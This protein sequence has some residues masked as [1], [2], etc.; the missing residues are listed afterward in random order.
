MNPVVASTTGG[1]GPYTYNVSPNLPSGLVLGLD[2]GISGT[3]TASATNATYRVQA[4]DSTGAT[5]IADID[6]EVIENKELVLREFKEATGRFMSRRIERTLSSDARLY[7]LE[8]RVPS[9]RSGSFSANIGSDETATRADLQFSLKHGLGNG[10]FA[11]VEGSYSFY[12]YSD[13][14]VPADGEYAVIHAGAD[15]QVSSN[16]VMGFMVSWDSMSE[17]ITAAYDISGDGYL[18]GPYFATAISEQLFLSG[19]LAFGKSDNS[20]EVDIN[21]TS[22]SGDFDTDRSL[23]TLTLT[24]ETKRGQATIRPEVSLAYA[25]ESQDDY[26]V[27]DGTFT[28]SVPGQEVSAA[29]AK[30]ATEVQLPFSHLG[31]RG[32]YYVRPSLSST[33]SENA[34]FLNSDLYGAIETGY[35]ATPSEAL[36]HGVSLEYFG[37]G[38]TAFEGL[39]L[40]AYLEFRF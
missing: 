18:V 30:I 35:H 4:E 13:S 36:G 11:W 26:F 34:N 3:P 22:Y 10:I 8:N 9:G 2:G 24:G 1:S 20:T 17:D 39:G 29:F 7:R 15:I 19:R 31:D 12:D 33:F 28:V 16:T 21:G 37:I 6:I 23:A 25:K 14:M 40:R 5:A 38:D 32:Y 27:T